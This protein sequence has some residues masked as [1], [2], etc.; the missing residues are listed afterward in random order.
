MKNHQKEDTHARNVRKVPNRFA[1]SMVRGSGCSK[2]RLAKAAG[3]KIAVQHRNEKWHH[4]RAKPNVQNTSGP[5][6]FLKCRCHVEKWHAG[7]KHFQVKMYKT[8][9]SRT[10]FCCSDV[11]KW[12]AAVAQNAFVTQNAKKLTVSGRFLKLRCTKIVR[13]VARSTF[14][15]Q[16]AKKKRW[17]RDTFLSSDVEKGMP[18]WREAHSPVKMR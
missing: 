15:T 6:R 18:L 16:N 1:F 9:Q 8:P 11:K 13:R 14:V 3:P 2:R 17:V 5:D 7:A 12:H 4:C 10:A